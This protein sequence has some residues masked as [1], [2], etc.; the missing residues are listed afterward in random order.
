MPLGIIANALAIIIGGLIGNYLGDKLTE[1]FEEKIT[2]IFGCCSLS[3]GVSSIVLMENMPAVVFSVIIGT[4][5]GILLH[6]EELVN[7]AG[8]VMQ[9]TVSRFISNDYTNLSEKEF[10]AT[11]LTVIVLFCASGTGIYG[12][13][14]SGV[15]G[16]HSILLAKSILDLFTA[17]IFACSLGSV[18]SIIAIPQF[19]IFIIFYLLGG[20][21]IPLTNSSMINDFK[22]CGG[23]LMLATGFRIIKLRMF[24][25]ADMIPAMFLVMP[26]SYLWVEYAIPWID[27]LTF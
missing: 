22:A 21:I 4:G 13:I 18:V 20:F 7:K 23:F 16:D 15:T 9:G 1:S 8:G 3:M 19:I 6:L 24:P 14:I 11:L 17:L 10:K 5:I 2:L 12:S 27:S 26:I 25:I